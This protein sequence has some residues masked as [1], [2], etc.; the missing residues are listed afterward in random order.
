MG[1]YVRDF[2][3]VQARTVSQDFRPPTDTHAH[4]SGYQWKLMIILL[5]R[6]EARSQTHP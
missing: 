2:D 5:A 1:A 3:E 4:D 6:K